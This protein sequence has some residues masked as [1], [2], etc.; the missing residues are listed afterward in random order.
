MDDLDSLFSLALQAQNALK[1]HVHR[2][3]LT[4]STYFSSVT[5]K[6]V[7]LKLENLQKTGSFKVRGAF[8]KISSLLPEV[9]TRGV[10]AASSGNHAQGVAYSASRLGVKAIIVMP[11]TAPPYKINATKSY[12][13]KVLLK[14]EIYD[15][16]YQEALR[17]SKKTGA[18]FIHPF[19]DPYVIA[20]QGTIGLE[21]AEELPEIDSVLVPVG[22]GG[23]I[24][25]IAL[26]LKH[27]YRDRKLNVIGVEPE[28]D[29]KLTRAL[30]AGKPISIT[31]KPSL[32]DG[33]LT[34]SVGRLT[35]K[36]IQS[37][38]DDVVIVS[39][40]YIAKAMY[41]L[42]ERTKLLAEG[43]GALPLAALLQHPT[44]IPGKK[45]VA[46]IS[47]GN[48]DL[49]TLYRVILRGLASEG[50]ITKI[51][52]KLKD[53]PG[54]LHKALSAVASSGCNIIDI[55]HDR[56]DPSVSPGFALVELLLETP[57][58]EAV[59]K[60]LSDLKGLGIEVVKHV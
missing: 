57:S 21:I 40:D 35:F 38:V 28:A 43:A 34:R 9:R 52:L 17:I 44:K 12:G 29:P 11:R 20:G 46:V 13:A 24:S 31:P 10:V 4:Y 55:R 23:L 16:A 42:L 59:E 45:V 37:T 27:L 22:G 48:A 50:R 6:D 25:G 58:S 26:T 7:Y 14:G 49:T 47:G 51:T 8:F 18:F 5:G 1:G 41:L 53:T 3:P 54:A 56:F 32:A 30:N 60:V 39:E 2:T 33:V 15:D 36:V 19:D